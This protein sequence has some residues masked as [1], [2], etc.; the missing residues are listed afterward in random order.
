MDEYNLPVIPEDPF[1]A[2]KQLEKD[3]ALPKG[4]YRKL[5]K[6]DDWSFVIKL[7]SLIEAAIS[8]LIIEALGHTQLSE[9]I[10]RLELSNNTTG[11]M[12]FVKALNLM[13]EEHRRY[14]RKLSEIRNDFVHGISNVSIDLRE[15][16]NK[17]G[18][19]E[20]ATK[21]FCLGIEKIEFDERKLSNVEYMRED[22]KYVIWMGGVVC[23]SL[24]YVKRLQA[25]HKRELR[26]IKERKLGQLEGLEMALRRRGIPFSE[27][28]QQSDK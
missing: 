7:H 27:S 11:K 8:S 24:A 9:A 10:S 19:S 1:E 17:P 4:F 15:Y 5:Y 2:I 6:E 23:L 12:A 22:P 28:D 25:I 21:A 18:K 16:L 3:L 20:A 14:I 26:K 13:N